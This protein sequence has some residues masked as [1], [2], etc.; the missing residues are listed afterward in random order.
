MTESLEG[1]DI[2][3]GPGWRLFHR[4]VHWITSRAEVAQAT[5]NAAVW[6]ACGATAIFGS[7]TKP[8]CD[9]CPPETP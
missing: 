3:N 2:P 8:R 9:N 5:P 7:A 6:C 1:L 4:V